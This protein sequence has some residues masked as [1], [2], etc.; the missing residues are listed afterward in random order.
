M[1]AVFTHFGKE[2]SYSKNW[3]FKSETLWYE[4]WEQILDLAA[5]SPNLRYLEIITWNDY[6]ESHYVGP[7]DNGHSDDGSGAWT[8]GLSHDA[9]LEFARPYITAFKTGSRRPVVDRDMLVYWYRPHLKSVSS[10]DGTDICGARPAGWDIVGD[11]VFVASFSTGGGSVS[12]KSGDKEQVT[13]SIG[14]GVN[15]M[16]F[17]M[18]VGEQVFSM[19]SGSRQV[20]GSGSS[21]VANSCWVSRIH[22]D[23]W[24]SVSNPAWIVPNC[25]RVITTLIFSLDLSLD[26]HSLATCYFALA[27]TKRPLNRFLF[28]KVQM[29][30]LFVQASQKINSRCIKLDRLLHRKAGLA[31]ML[32]AGSYHSFPSN[33][34][35][36][37]CVVDW[38]FW[39]RSLRIGCWAKLKI[40][41]MGVLSKIQ[42]VRYWDS[43][44]N[45]DPRKK[46]YRTGQKVLLPLRLELRTLCA[47]QV[48]AC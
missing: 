40:F 46:K 32:H 20:S 44:R 12:V 5:R 19:S 1:V 48:K 37:N 18:G 10:C 22:S 30:S 27:I 24:S 16:Q 21:P 6:G 23:E 34:A 36:T 45:E 35:L 2:V 13:K 38:D 25:R 3:L 29:Q 41:R 39:D 17:D 26:L 9:L 42:R 33:H 47:L 7:S 43:R 31:L 28:T 4:R 8:N 14:P 11:S 15:M